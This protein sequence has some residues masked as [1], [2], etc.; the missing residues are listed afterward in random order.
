M[1]SAYKG[2]QGQLDELYSGDQAKAVEYVSD[3]YNELGNN[4]ALSAADLGS[5]L[6]RSASSLS[7][8]GNTIQESAAMATGITEVTQDSERAGSALKILALRLRGTSAKEMEDL[9]EETDGL[10]ETTSKLKDTILTLTNNKVN[11][12]LDDGSYKSTYQITKEISDVYG[13]LSDKQQAGLLETIA[14]KSRSNDVAA[15]ISN[16]SQVENAYNSA[17]NAE[18]SA[19]KENEIYMTHIEA[20]TKVLKAN[21][22]SLSIMKY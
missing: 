22:Q 8:A 10:V 20:R 4:Y 7:L 13:E 12:E 16:F 15:L 2:F 3:I 11:I 21:L 6:E 1:V 9:G 14:G 19:R 5:A 17:M 18:G